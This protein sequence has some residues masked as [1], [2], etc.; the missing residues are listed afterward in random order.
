[1][2]AEPP[3][4]TRAALRA[5]LARLGLRPGDAVMAHGALSRVGRLLG[6]PDAVIGALLDA[7]SPGGTVLA[8]TDW[9]ARYDEL[10]D[11]R[12]RVPPEW[13]AHVPPFDRAASRASRDNGVLP[14]FL[15]TWPGARRSGNPGASVAALGARAE[16]FTA[17]HPLDYGYGPG[18][19]LATLVEA[20]GKVVMIG[21][22]L[23]TMTLLHHAEHLADL[24][25]KRVIRYEVPFATGG[26]VEWRTVEE[27]DTAQPVVEAFGDDHFAAI[28]TDF[29]AGGRG[30]RGRVGS[31]DAVLVDADAICAFAVR[32]MEERAGSRSPAP[33]RRT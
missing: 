20:R 4:V 11:D 22:P 10:L 3:F 17:D 23:D 28:V 30:V 21:A 31:A 2:V 13:R 6:G 19:P 18:S 8:Y 7:V 14:E 16:R 15:R 26:G 9:D 32:W 27:F 5:D 29:L 1:V 33:P 25:G 12:G 24:P